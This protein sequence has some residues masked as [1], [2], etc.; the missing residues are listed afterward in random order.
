MVCA[1]CSNQRRDTRSCQKKKLEI[2]VISDVVCPWCY[3]GKRRLDKALADQ[4]DL[5]VTVR[6]QPFQLAPDM[7]RAGRRRADYYAEK[8][9]AGAPR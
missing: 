1:W 8:F 7:P 4:P 9:G 6:W 3:V 5:D 2:D